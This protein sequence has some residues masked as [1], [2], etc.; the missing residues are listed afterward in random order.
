MILCCGEAL[1]DMIPQQS[2]SAQGGFVPR[3]GGAAFNTAIALARQGA[4]AGLLTGLSSDRFGRKLDAELARAG[5]DRSLIITSDHPTTLAHVQLDGDEATYS[6]DDE[7]SAGRMLTPEDLPELPDRV[8]CLLLGGISLCH[9][10]AADAYEALSNRAEGR[11]VM[12]DPN[13]RPGFITDE[14]CYRARLAR[15]MTRAHIVKLSEPDLN[16]LDPRP[17]PLSDKL[18]RILAAG[19]FLVLFTQGARGVTARHRD[20]RQTEVGAP[21][22]QVSG[23]VG[24][25]DAFNAGFLA[26]LATLDQLKPTAIGHLPSPILRDCLEHATQVAAQALSRSAAV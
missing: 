8:G 14:V 26:R 7:N 25:G 12:L 1:I 3:C 19:P 21:K 16:W 11:L 10:P 17:L 24:A 5:V 18:D 9:A 20:G 22:V 13:I 15:M 6:F 4:R 23:T 2:V